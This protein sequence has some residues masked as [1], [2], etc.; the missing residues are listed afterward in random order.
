MNDLAKLSDENTTRILDIVEALQPATAQQV[1]G[2]LERRH[3]LRA[4]IEQVTRYM[5]FLRSNFP[6]KLAHAGPELW[7]V[8]DLG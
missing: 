8:V 1:Q 2:E 3:G 4:P 7:I 6:R 5:E